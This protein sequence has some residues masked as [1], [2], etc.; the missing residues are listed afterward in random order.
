MR[1]DVTWGPTIPVNPRGPSG[2]ASPCERWT[3][4]HHIPSESN[5]IIH[6]T[7]TT[8]ES[9]HTT[10]SK[11]TH[12]HLRNRG[13]TH[14]AW[15]KTRL[16]GH[17]ISSSLYWIIPHRFCGVMDIEWQLYKNV[18]DPPVH[19]IM[20]LAAMNFSF[21]Q[22]TRSSVTGHFK[23]FDFD[24]TR[25]VCE[26][27]PDNVICSH[28]GSLNTPTTC[29]PDNRS[30]FILSYL[31]KELL[32]FT[33]TFFQKNMKTKQ[34]NTATVMVLWWKAWMKKTHTEEFQ[35]IKHIDFY[36]I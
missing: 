23:S 26:M 20:T 4:Q 13:K 25:E 8:T 11:V 16:D 9:N 6:E 22:A 10:E 24:F 30:N 35:N 27:N 5:S 29:A 21:L 18:P 7:H 34:K 33:S 17:I 28:W 2:P 15:Q 19:R 12:E 1:A 3:H 36:T 32:S 14:I 31:L